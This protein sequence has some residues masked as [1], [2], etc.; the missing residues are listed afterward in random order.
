V[1]SDTDRALFASVSLISE[2]T[3]QGQRLVLCH[4][5]F[6]EWN[7]CWRGS[8]HLFGH[9]HGRLDHLPNGRSLD[10][11]VDAHEFRPWRLEE[12]AA[13][14]ETRDNPFTDRK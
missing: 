11:G 14:M 13:V 1:L 9:V 7:N 4:Y 5:P 6:R 3:H 2:I 10:V 8:W 12:I